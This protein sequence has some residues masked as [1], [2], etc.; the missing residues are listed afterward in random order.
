MKH[1]EH[2]LLQVR[3]FAADNKFDILTIRTLAIIDAPDDTH[4]GLIPN[5]ES[6]RAYG[7]ED[8]KRV[9]C[10]DF[11]CEKAF[12]IPAVFADGTLMPCDQD[13]NGQQPY[14]S[15]AD[16]TSFADIWWSK[17][18]I[19]IRKTIRD[20]PDNFSFCLNCPFRDRP[21][22]PMSTEYYNLSGKTL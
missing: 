6:Y 2:E 14:G 18:A 22:G 16:G 11:I 3:E 8:N 17:Q 19:R 4:L 5:N 13:C 10:S 21:V 15:L 20:N 12:T 1:N 9:I 7:Y